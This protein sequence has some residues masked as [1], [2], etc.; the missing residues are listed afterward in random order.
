MASKAKS[1]WADDE[2]DAALDAQLKKQK[3]EKKRLKAQKAVQRNAERQIQETVVE[4]AAAA[5]APA[6]N[7]APKLLRFEGGSFGRSRTLVNYD[8]LND[9]GQGAYGFVSRA[10][11]VATGEVF[12]LKRLKFDPSTDTGGVPVTALR[13]IQV[14]KACDHRNVVKMKEVVVGEETGRVERYSPIPPPP[15][16]PNTTS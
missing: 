7:D 10:K 13:E 12:A 11:E 5:P 8:K 6:A 9:I 1:R 2:A 15:A 14:L 4:A 16:K 3:E